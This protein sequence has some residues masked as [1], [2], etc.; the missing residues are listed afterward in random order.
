MEDGDE[1]PGF[2]DPPDDDDLREYFFVMIACVSCGQWI[3]RLWGEDIDLNGRASASAD[4]GGG[5]A[6]GRERLPLPCSTCG[7]TRASNTLKSLMRAF[8]ATRKTPV[9]H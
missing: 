6:R 2:G 3:G 4:H 7:V 5:V 1:Y 9:A 8:R